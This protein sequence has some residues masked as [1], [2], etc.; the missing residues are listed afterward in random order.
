MNCFGETYISAMHVRID[1]FFALLASN[2]NNKKNPLPRTAV[3]VLLQSSVIRMKNS[4]GHSMTSIITMLNY[5]KM[6]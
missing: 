1:S 4:L 2:N 6:R 3:A 5:V